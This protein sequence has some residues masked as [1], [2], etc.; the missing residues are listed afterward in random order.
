MYKEELVWKTVEC[1]RREEMFDS[2]MEQR[3]L[4][5][6]EKEKGLE[7]REK[8]LDIR[9]GACIITEEAVGNMRMEVALLN[10][11]NDAVLRRQSRGGTL[12]ELFTYR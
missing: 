8:Q 1:E 5:M 4:R 2:E 12:L 11:R 10:I 6:R 7:E 9:E 3:E